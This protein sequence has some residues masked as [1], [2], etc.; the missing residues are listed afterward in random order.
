MDTIRFL[1]SWRE[2]PLLL[3]LRSLIARVCRF[4]GWFQR[5]NHGVGIA[6][7]LLQS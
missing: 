5:E 1:V 7:L 3:A 2:F 4:A 6:A